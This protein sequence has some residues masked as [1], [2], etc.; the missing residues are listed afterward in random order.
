[1]ALAVPLKI[2]TIYKP[3]IF[4]PE[5]KPLL[6]KGQWSM[7]QLFLNNARN[8]PQSTEGPPPKGFPDPKAIPIFNAIRVASAEFEAKTIPQANELG[9]K[10]Y[11]YGSTAVATFKAIIE[12]MDQPSP[13]KDVLLQLFG[14]AKDMAGESETQ[15]KGVSDKV[16]DYAAVLTTEESKLKIV[17][18]EE[19]KSGGGLQ[20]QIDR[21][22]ADINQQNA[23]IKQAQAAIVSDQKVIDDTVYYSWIPFI[24]TIVALAEIITKSDDIQAQ[25]R[26]I[27]AAVT[28]IQNDHLALDPL[29]ARVKQLNYAVTFNGNQINQ[30][31]TMGVILGK[32]RSAWSTIDKILGNILGNINLAQAN[33]LKN[34]P[35]LSAVELTAATSQWQR[36]ANDAHNY[37][38]NFYVKAAEQH[39]N[40]LKAA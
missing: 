21:L 2:S 8:L 20:A 5:N 10:L 19:V 37:M 7:V 17:V 3:D 13:D 6:D 16:S 36:V 35:A 4:V 24:G 32:I 11:N 30:M 28:N 27:K 23:A 33:Q 18:E 40:V 9:N 38:M 22:V 12:I 1:M 15:A 31:D 34:M 25:Y 29:N 39:A 14:N 26:T